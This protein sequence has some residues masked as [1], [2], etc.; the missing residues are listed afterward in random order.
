MQY[1]AVVSSEERGSQLAVSDLLSRIGARVRARRQ[2]LGYSLKALAA[3]S[4]LSPRFLSDVEAGRGNIAVGRLEQVARAL[5]LPVAALVSEQRVPGLRGSIE[6]LLDGRTEVELA[7]LSRLLELAVGVRAPQ[8]IAL[9]G[10]RG[11]GKSTVGA[12]AGKELGLPFVE[13]ADR[14]EVLAGMPLSEIFGF[15][16]EPYYRRLEKHCLATL[17]EEGT[18]CVVALPGGIVGNDE[19]FSL[20]QDSCFS[21]WLKAEPAEYWNRVLAQ[22]DY[23]PIRGREDAMQELKRLVETRAEQYRRADLVLETSGVSPDE[24]VA[25][26]TQAAVERGLARHQ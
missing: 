18:S 26:L 20:V 17:L 19:A 10:L 6:A 4:G 2:E 1:I 5:D 12:S 25:Q 21:I 23:R 22:G 24:V 13:L 3:A 15:H 11:A 9:L 7:R 16:G 8:V 14:V